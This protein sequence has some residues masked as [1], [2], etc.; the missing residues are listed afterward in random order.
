MNP[1]KSEEHRGGDTVTAVSKRSGAPNGASR[2]SPFDRWL[3]YPAGFSRSALAE[4]FG[5]LDKAEAVVVD[6]FAGVA[7]AGTRAIEG[8]Y[9]FRG[10][11]VHPLVAAIAKLKFDPAGPE[12]AL[13]LEDEARRIVNDPD[14]DELELSEEASLVQRSFDTQTL[15]DLVSL[16]RGIAA[17]QEGTRPYLQCALVGT[18]RDV[19]SVK[20]GWPYQQPKVSRKPVHRSALERFMTRVTWITE[21]LGRL[22]RGYDARLTQ[23]DSRKS[24]S[25]A[26]AL[27]GAKADACISSPP[28][29]NNYDYADATRLELYFL[30]IVS[31]WAELCSEV[32]SGMVAATTQQSTLGR[33]EAG[34]KHLSGAPNTLREASR[35]ANKLK[36][37]RD[38]RS[39]GKEYDQMLPAYLGDLFSVLSKVHE[40]LDAGGVVAWVVGDSA[41][42]GVYI[43][44]PDLIARLAEE[45]GFELCE[46][47]KLRTR[48]S[49]W[50]TNGSRHQVK[51]SERLIVMRR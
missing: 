29:L 34:W 16:R 26:E 40:N 14:R 6:P 8:G 38:Q 15:S 35:L 46:D 2:R 27:K 5:R 32:R 41:P 10:I 44:T 47:K 12:V 18:L 1:G 33:A 9:V 24:C 13:T 23:G 45:V 7:T 4:C 43:D 37:E 51:L 3:R 21:D 50:A 28:Y 39:R 36:K 19:A 20:V 30:G 42:Y 11:E 31:T 49:R 22:P 17:S 48:G 25:W